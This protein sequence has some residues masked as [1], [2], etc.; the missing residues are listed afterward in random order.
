MSAILSEEDLNDFISPG[1]ACIKPVDNLSE[2][3][4][5]A[6]VEIQTGKKGETVEV[7][8]VDGSSKNLLEAQISLSDCLACSGCI[9][10]AE[11]VLVAQH[12][13]NEFLKVLDDPQRGNKVFVASIAHQPRASLA[14]AYGVPVGV[15]DRLLVNFF[16]T[17]MGFS[18]VVGTELGRKLSLIEESKKIIERKESASGRGPLLSSVCP[19]L[20]LYVEKSHPY[21]IPY[22][23]DTKSPQ[24]ITG[25]LL[26]NTVARELNVAPSDIFHLSV[27]PCFDKK[28]ESAR[29]E[30]DQ[31]GN[32]Q[33]RDVDFVITAKELINLIEENSPRFSLFP[34][35]TKEI[36]S[37]EY[38]NEQIQRKY[39]PQFWP[40][41][42]A[43]WSSD[44]G[45]AS[46]GYSYNYLAMMQAHLIAKDPRYVPENFLLKT[47]MGRNADIYE[48]RL[49]YEGEI[50]AQAAV[51]NGFRNIQNLIRKLKPSSS[52]SAGRTNLLASRRRA[53]VSKT[54]QQK[55]E[56]D[57]EMTDASKCDYVEVMACPQGCINGGGQISSPP[58]VS[59]KA[60]I[61]ET[62]LKYNDIPHSMDMLNWGY[63]I[64][65][66]LLSWTGQFC[67]ESS[68]SQS[69][70]LQT[71]F[72]EVEK[73]DES[74]AS[75]PVLVGNKW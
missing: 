7:S 13:H 25:C 18:Y 39:A 8:K 57:D 37:G 9:T 50:C 51:V 67:V 6:E 74:Q 14:A 23:S 71:W 45:S 58:E 40:Y 16:T 46:G 38:S 53:K 10:S 34:T 75:N 24:Q 63:D 69:R 22:L 55:A 48:L 1:V 35:N 36:L 20:V 61:A 49:L 68:I 43:S 26:K 19:G 2:K 65:Q 11:E 64:V 15:M 21:V 44:E 31:N 62:L 70:L 4:E 5:D 54:P 66:S 32:N 27:M 52:S 73:P 56:R 30:K 12:S 72:H 59:D 28:L 47:V 29:P 41:T 33:T 60:W 42:D 3:E 17:Q